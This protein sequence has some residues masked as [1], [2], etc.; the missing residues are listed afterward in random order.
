MGRT[1]RKMV[2]VVAR[3][4]YVQDAGGKFI[5][6]KRRIIQLTVQKAGKPHDTEVEGERSSL[7]SCL[8]RP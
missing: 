5:K 3:P 2:S 7:V 8:R 1:E 6:K 4:C